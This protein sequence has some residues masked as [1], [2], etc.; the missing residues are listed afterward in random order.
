MD[1]VH[2]DASSSSIVG[3]ISCRSNVST[4]QLPTNDRGVHMQTHRLMGWIYEVWRWDGLRCH[5][6]HITFHKGWFR[7]SKVDGDSQTHRQ[8]CDL[9]SQLLFSQSKES[10]LKQFSIRIWL[11]SSWP[12]QRPDRI[13]SFHPHGRKQIKQVNT[14]CRYPLTRFWGATIKV[15]TGANI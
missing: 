1:R 7:H 15:F 12:K 4:E 5:D 6:M 3:C 2:N 11:Q 13:C 9:I 8:Y 14:K 10:K